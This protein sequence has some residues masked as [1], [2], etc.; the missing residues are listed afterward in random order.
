MLL[1]ER[2]TERG[3]LVSVCD[4]GLLGETFENGQ[5]SITVNESFYG[6]EDAE[7]VG[8][9]AVVAGLQ[10]ASIANLVGEECVEVAVDAGVVDEHAVIDVGGT[11][12]AQLLRL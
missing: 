8:A 9:D 3:L 10:R 5:V 2:D 12:H 6:G 11:L 7:T 1:R 4:D